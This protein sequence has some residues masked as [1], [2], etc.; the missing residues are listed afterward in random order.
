[1]KFNMLIVAG[2]ALVALSWHACSGG[3]VADP[4][5]VVYHQNG[6]LSVLG[7]KTGLDS[8]K[9][10]LKAEIAKMPALPDA[11]P[12]EFVGEVLMGSRQEVESLVNEAIF[13]AKH[14]QAATD[15]I[16]GFYQWYFGDNTGLDS[17]DFV[18]VNEGEPL[19]LDLAKLDAYYSVVKS[20]GFVSDEL[21]QSEKDYFKKCEALWKEE[22]EGPYSCLEADRFTCL[23]DS[24]DLIRDDFT[25]TPVLVTYAGEDRLSA[26]IMKAGMEAVLELKLENGKWLLANTPCSVE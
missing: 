21:I 9:L 3:S 11:I 18:V 1:M 12:V 16:H 20:T 14:T 13:E 23:Q 10:I 25:K 5:K 17:V 6:E 19:K 7:Q 24:P 15:V 22:S 8:L 26:A 4:T 2:C